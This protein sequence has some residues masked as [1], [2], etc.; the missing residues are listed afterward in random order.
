MFVRGVAL[1]LS[2]AASSAALGGVAGHA[3]LFG[4]APDLARFA[5]CLLQTGATHTGRDQSVFTSDVI[6]EFLRPE[7]MLAGNGWTLGWSRPDAF[8][9]AGRYFSPFARGHLGYTGTSLWI[10]FARK[11]YV[12]ILTNRVHPSRDR[13]G[14]TTFRATVHDTIFEHYRGPAW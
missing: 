7:T 5:E 13:Q 8:A 10:D 1:C 11:M 14:I 9:S 12:I 3:G 6:G 4:N 2:L